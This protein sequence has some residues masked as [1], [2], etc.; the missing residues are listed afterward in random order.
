LKSKRPNASGIT[1]HTK[2]VEDQ[3]S[4]A[5]QLLHFLRDTGFTLGDALNDIAGETS[6]TGDIFWAVACTD[7]AAILIEILIDHKV[8]AILYCPVTAIHFENALRACLFWC[9]AGHFQD[10]PWVISPDFL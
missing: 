5:I 4:I 6:Q 10:D 9:T 7:A 3:A 8:T 2:I 1:S